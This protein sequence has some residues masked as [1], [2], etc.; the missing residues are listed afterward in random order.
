[1]LLEKN[2]SVAVPLPV[3]KTESVVGGLVPLQAEEIDA[4]TGGVSIYVDGVYRGEGSF[5]YWPWPSGRSSSGA[6]VVFK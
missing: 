6:P 4:V 3:G 2:A 1:M 5:D